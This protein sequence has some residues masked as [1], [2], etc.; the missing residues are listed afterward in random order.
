M[1]ILMIAGALLA[2]MP[3]SAAILLTNGTGYTGPVL[4]LS[5][6]PGFYTFTAGPVSLPGGITYTSTSAGSVIGTGGYSLNENGSAATTPIV[7][8]NGTTDAI[9]LTFAN[10]VSAFGAGMSYAVIGGVPVGSNAPVISA[11]DINGALI[12][13]YDL[14]ALAPIRSNGANEFFLFRGIDGQG[15]GIKSFTM[16]GA[17][18]IA[19]GSFTSAVVPEPASWAMLIAGFG[20]VGATMRRRRA[21]IA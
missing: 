13:S 11:F 7:G 16:S 4:D 3:A 20:L 2:S 5:A 18:I 19:S 1:R 21:A 15:T 6:F 8:T 17:F 9:T 10:P 12:A 14:E